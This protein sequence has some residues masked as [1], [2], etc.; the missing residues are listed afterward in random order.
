M[1]WRGI[2]GGLSKIGGQVC[3]AWHITPPIQIQIQN[4]K[5]NP[6]TSKVTQFQLMMQWSPSY[7]EFK[8]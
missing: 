1:G 8:K 2:E 7:L 6:N 5:R 3:A 4:K